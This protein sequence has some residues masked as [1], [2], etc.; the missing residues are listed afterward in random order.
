MIGKRDDASRRAVA[1]ASRTEMYSKCGHATA[2]SL[3]NTAGRWNFYL[4]G[5]RRSLMTLNTRDR[6]LVKDIVE[7]L[8]AAAKRGGP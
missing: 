8:G 4:S 7:A 3:P 5:T 1:D 2:R 6:Q